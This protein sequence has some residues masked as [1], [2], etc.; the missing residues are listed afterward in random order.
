MAVGAPIKEKKRMCDLLEAITFLKTH[1]LRGVSVIRGYHS[2]RVAPLM[3]CALPL[4]GMMPGAQLVRT[5]LAKGLLHD[6]E[7][8]QHI[9]EATGEANTM[10]SIL[11]HP[12]MQPG[13]GFI[14]LPMGLVF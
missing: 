12:L 7:V 1:G 13:A 5:M 11:G 6:S 10:F 14:E 3:A 9:K 2:R 4:Y 8:A